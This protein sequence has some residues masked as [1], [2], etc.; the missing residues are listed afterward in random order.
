MT[1]G[2]DYIEY[3]D[4]NEQDQEEGHYYFTLSEFKAIVERH[5]VERVLKD[6]DK[7]TE[8]KIY[9]CY[10]KQLKMKRYE[11]DDDCPF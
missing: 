8:E 10:F 9:W 5:G 6:L 11:A 2:S 7:D 3:T 1:N 4:Y